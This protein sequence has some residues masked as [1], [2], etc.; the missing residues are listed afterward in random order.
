MHAW[1][2][3]LAVKM[4]VKYRAAQS[5]EYKAQSTEYEASIER[6]KKM[7]EDQKYFQDTPF[8]Y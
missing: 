4:L 3:E 2:A 6:A 5:T 7:K 8:F 1:K